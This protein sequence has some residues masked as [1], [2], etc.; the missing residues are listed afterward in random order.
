MKSHGKS[1]CVL[2]HPEK[3]DYSLEAKTYTVQL[4]T[5][6]SQDAAETCGFKKKS[7]QLNRLLQLTLKLVRC[8]LNESKTLEE[9]N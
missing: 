6:Q 7:S 1:P 5:P 8:E 3:L 4:P 2:R 9:D